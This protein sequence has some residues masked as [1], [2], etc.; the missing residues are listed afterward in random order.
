MRDGKSRRGQGVRS[1]AS[2]AARALSVPA[3][4]WQSIPGEPR[5]QL[6]VALDP[7]HC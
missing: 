1:G 6:Q 5:Y 3:A 7:A 2:V 4:R